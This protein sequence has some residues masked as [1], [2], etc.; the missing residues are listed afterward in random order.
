[1][2]DEDRIAR[3]A[4]RLFEEHRD[5]LPMA[6][7]PED[8]RPRDIAEAYV[9]QDRLLDLYAAQ[10]HRVGGWKIALTTP[11]MQE[12]VG[13][14]RP[15]E[16]AIFSDRIHEGA[17]QVRG[18]DFRKLGV[19]SEIAMRLDRDLGAEGAPYDRDTVAEAVG[20]CMAGIEIVD[21]RDVVYDQLDAPLLIADNSMNQGCVI[22]GAVEDWRALDLG[23]AAGRMIIN[24][25]VVGEGHGRDAL[26]HPLLA[27]AWLANNLVERG[28][29][30]H[31]GDVV[32]TGSIVTTKF[33]VAGDEMVT[34]IDGLGNARLVVA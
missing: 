22:G 19:E 3:A 14:D 32:L 13:I 9:A 23:A 10:G 27:L 18:A 26:G 24:G 11:V 21:L 34:T 28:R 7:L 33:M 6:P 15:C 4:R 20:V 17:V 31:A 29:M 5:R 16:G 25:E 12:M 8:A 2:T 30:L 1:M